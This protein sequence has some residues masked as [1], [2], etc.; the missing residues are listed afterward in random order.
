MN[1]VMTIPTGVGCRIG[2]HAG[3][4]TPVA[5]M[6]SQCCDR[7]FL[8]PN[9]VN[10]SNI[11]DLPEN[12]L[13]VEGSILDRFLMG[14]IELQPVK[15]NKVLVVVNELEPEIIN[16][17]SAAR[18]VSG[19]DAEVLQLSTPLKMKAFLHN[20]FADGAYSGVKELIAQV[21]GLVF[22]ALAIVSPITIEE[23]VRDSYIENGQVN[24]WGRVESIVSRIVATALNKPVAHAP[25]VDNQP[26]SQI[27]DPRKSAEFISATFSY[28]ILRGLQKAPRIG[29]GLDRTTVDALVIPMHCWNSVYESCKNAGIKV[30]IVKENSTCYTHCQYPTGEGLIFVEN[31][32]EAAGYIMCLKGGID[33]RAARRPLKETR[34]NGPN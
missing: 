33:P 26:F 15:N 10:A 34:Y 1:I 5:K 29:K 4:A 14:W 3:D 17:V 25:S 8:H 6:L 7:L 9:V 28:C 20:G 19:V 18:A 30:I 13:Y 22:D 11:I 2:G 27:I 24:P 21:K 16:T 23:S 32:W 12:A 31:Y